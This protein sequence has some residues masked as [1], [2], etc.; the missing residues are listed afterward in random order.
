[1]AMV[2]M[3]FFI[4]IGCLLQV[5]AMMNVTGSNSFAS[6]EVTRRGGEV[7]HPKDEI[8]LWTANH[9]DAGHI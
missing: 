5:A 8:P 1:M 3:L 7:F 4:F 6:A 9:V 2:Q